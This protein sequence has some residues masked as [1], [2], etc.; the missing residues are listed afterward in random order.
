MAEALLHDPRM[1][2]GLVQRDG[3]K[4]CRPS[5]S[6]MIGSPESMT[7]R[8][9]WRVIVLGARGR[10]ISSA[11]TKSSVPSSHPGVGFTNRLRRARPGFRT[12]ASVRVW[13]EGGVCARRI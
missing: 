7:A 13:L 8:V 5:C 2:A 3:G 6:R 9:Q 4:L 12:S 11:I 1:L 10:P